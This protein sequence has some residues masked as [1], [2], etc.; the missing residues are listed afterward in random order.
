MRVIPPKNLLLLLEAS[1]HN[2]L[3]SIRSLNRGYG[4]LVPT[5]YYWYRTQLNAIHILCI[6]D[7]EDRIRFMQ[8]NYGLSVAD[9]EAAVDDQVVRR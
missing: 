3:Y 2:C 9:A 5:D 8:D 6:A 4:E 7:F 1:S